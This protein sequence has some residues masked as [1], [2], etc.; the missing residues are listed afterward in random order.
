[1]GQEVTDW[2]RETAERITLDATRHENYVP[3]DDTFALMLGIAIAAMQAQQA[4]SQRT[5]DPYGKRLLEAERE[6]D[7]ALE[8]LRAIRE[9]VVKRDR[10]STHWEGCETQHLGCFI[11]RSIGQTA[12]E[13]KETTS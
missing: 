3:S 2:Q 13:D 7:E 12:T 9:C 8:K 5:L 10:S 1:M 11:L 4:E 6:R